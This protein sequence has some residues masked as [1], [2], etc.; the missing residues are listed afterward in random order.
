MVLVFNNG[1]FGLGSDAQAGGRTGSTAIS[2]DA[3]IITVLHLM[4]YVR[5][6]RF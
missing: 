2:L 3:T 5:L 4:T 6:F 1:Y